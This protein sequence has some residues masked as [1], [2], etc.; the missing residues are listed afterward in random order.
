MKDARNVKLY[1]TNYVRTGFG[2]E[3][4]SEEQFLESVIINNDEGKPIR[5]EHYL[6]NDLLDYI[7]INEYDD[8]GNLIAITQYDEEE[9]FIQK[10]EN[11]YNEDNV[12]IRQ[13]SLFGEGAPVYSI[14]YVYQDGVLIKED[15]YDEDEFIFTEKEYSYNDNKQLVKQVEYDEEGN[16]QYITVNEYNS[17]GLLVRKIIEEVQQ[18]DR[19]TFCY[20]YDDRGNRVKE[21]IYNYDNR[22]LEKNDFTFNEDNLLIEKEE[23]NQD[24]HQLTRYTYNGKEVEKVEILDNKG[25]VMMWVEYQYDENK[26]PAIIRNFTINE[27][28]EKSYR[29]LSEYRYERD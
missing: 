27:S 12:L 28:D 23:K 18:K 5:E 14:R 20:E 6:A 24:R 21:L 16:T 17:E 25:K 13:D 9:S 8:K 3:D 1:C 26:Q 11:H 19:R 2:K 7:L 22:L 29:L 4:F 15:S 10:T